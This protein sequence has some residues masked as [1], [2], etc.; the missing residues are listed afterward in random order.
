MPSW[1]DPIVPPS[2]ELLCRRER[3]LYASDT[4]SPV[5]AVARRFLERAAAGGDLFC[6][7][8]P[9]VMSYLR[10]ATHPRI[11]TAPL[12][13]SE[14]LGN[15]QAL[16]SLPHVRLLAEE[17]GFLDVYRVVTGGLPVRGNLVPDAHLASLLKQHGVRSL[18]SRDADFRKFAFLD[19][20]DPFA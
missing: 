19:L 8:W 14:A 3:L 13:P 1:I 16:A 4:S 15:V 6:L 9:T 2:R 18:F 12:A 11:F 10:M 5:H 17:P 20:H 7:G